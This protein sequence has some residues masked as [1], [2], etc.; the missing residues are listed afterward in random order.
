M[1]HERHLFELLENVLARRFVR[2]LIGELLNDGRETRAFL[3]E[4]I[5]LREEILRRAQ[6]SL[7]SCEQIHGERHRGHV[8]RALVEG[9]EQ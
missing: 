7:A 4:I 6:G 1:A 3:D 8:F 5:R 9:G 2:Y